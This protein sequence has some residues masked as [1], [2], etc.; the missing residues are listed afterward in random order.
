M[1]NLNKFKQIQIVQVYKKINE[2]DYP[3]NAKII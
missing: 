1:Y 2:R 3:A